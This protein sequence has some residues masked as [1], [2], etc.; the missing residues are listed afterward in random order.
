MER[1]RR[2]FQVKRNSREA[3]GNSPSAVVV[4]VNLST[5]DLSRQPHHPAPVLGPNRRD[6]AVFGRVG[7][8][9]RFFFGFEFGADEDGA[10]DLV[11]EEGRSGGDVSEDKRGL[12]EASLG[13]VRVDCSLGNHLE[14][15]LLG[16]FQE[17]LNAGKLLGGNDAADF[18]ILLPR[19]ATERL[20]L[21]GNHRKH[22]IVDRRLDQQA[23]T[24]GAGLSAVLDNRVDQKRKCLVEIGVFKDDLR[25]LAAEFH[26]RGFVVL[27]SEL[28][29]NGS[30][31]R[32][33]GEGNVVNVRVLGESGTGLGAVS[34]D[35][36]QGTRGEPDFLGELADAEEGLAGVLSRFRNDC[37]AGGKGTGK[38][39]AKDLHWVVFKYG[40]NQ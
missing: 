7:E 9:E 27:G 17:P 5:L 29:D 31:L 14:L 33:T 32:R 11:V 1:V 24:S 40:W 18:Q 34:S 10:K 21:L 38:G 25:R 15:V 16:L 13:C 2:S 36:V 28:G 6:E 39:T 22:F 35:Q 23:R 8:L 19:S 12:V 30:R 4:N 20:E 37:V 26:G 3:W